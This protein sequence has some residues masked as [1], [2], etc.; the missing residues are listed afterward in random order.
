M[1]RAMANKQIQTEQNGRSFVELGVESLG[2]FDVLNSR[3]SSIVVNA[4][5]VSLAIRRKVNRANSVGY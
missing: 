5:S 3:P 2:E 4:S 1:E